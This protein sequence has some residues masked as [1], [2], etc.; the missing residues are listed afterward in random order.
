[1]GL[2]S[3]TQ[4]LP[5]GHSAEA[6]IDIEGLAVSLICLVYYTANILIRFQLLEDHLQRLRDEDGVI[7]NE[8]DEDEAA[9][10]G[11]DIESDS[12]DESESEGWIDVEDNDNNTLNI[13]DSEDEGDKLATG[14]QNAATR[15]T[16]LATTK[17]SDIVGILHWY[18]FVDTFRGQILT[19]ADFAL[20]ND[21]RIQE[22][23]K[24]VENGGGSH[25]KRKLATLEANKRSLKSDQQLE[26]SFVSENDIL[27][28]R[29]KAKSDYA[30][31]MASIQK[32]REGREK[33]KSNKGKVNKETP[34]SSTNREKARNKPIMMILSSGAVRSKK[35]ASLREKQQKLRAHIEKAKKARH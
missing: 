26:N 2:A 21:L 28:P 5:F 22:A 25:A 16:T 30:E 15:R 23:N 4:P 9:W 14:A 20:L 32:G 17:V 35:K 31:R 8:D 6:A 19:P 12:S 27:G 10:Q 13:S 34:S 29:K 11:W 24:G 18:S 1:M 3:G 7:M 33:Y